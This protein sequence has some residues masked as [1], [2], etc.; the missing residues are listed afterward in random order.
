M[1][2]NF[3]K[4]VLIGVVVTLLLI[5]L[6][7]YSFADRIMILED[8][9]KYGLE[10]TVNLLKQ[11]AVSLGWK[12]PTTHSL[13]KSVAKA[14]YVVDPAVVV[15]LC[16]PN[17]AGEILKNYSDRIVS[18]MM[19]CRISVYYNENNEVIVSRMNTGLISK[20]FGGNISDI[21]SVATKDTE[22]I[23]STVL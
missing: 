8:K 7:A 6:S 18:S 12:V 13:N 14:G 11:E 21:M 2:N 20:L 5:F 15:E 19:P 1:K 23:I 9:S 4:G 16:N 3:V 17:Y 22:K 10:E